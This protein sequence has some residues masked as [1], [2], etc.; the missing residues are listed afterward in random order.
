MTTEN[1][2]PDGLKDLDPTKKGAEQGLYRKF[3]VRRVDGSDQPGGKHH[4]SEYFV[5]DLKHDLHAR[6]AIQAYAVACATT[7]PHLSV[8][9]IAR[10]GFGS[11]ASHEA[12]P[13][14]N[15]NGDTSSLIRSILWLL[16]MDAAGFLAPDVFN[17]HGRKLLDGAAGR[18]AALPTYN[19]GPKQPS[20]LATQSVARTDDR[21]NPLTAQDALAA[22]DTFE[23][24]GEN[25]Q[26]R[27]PNSEDRFI[28]EE[29]I[30]HLFGGYTVR[31]PADND[32]H[33]MPS[34]GSDETGS[35]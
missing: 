3:D 11:A 22:I 33:G 24:V 35:I 1:I 5:L 20:R 34:G 23:I 30:A 4:D 9:L 26:S 8:D 19:P 29:F 28:L 10:Y 18:L 27:E 6:A 25:N 12:V 2:R 32:T 21:R 14:D 17:A 15:F 31:R 7:H 16:E 13:A